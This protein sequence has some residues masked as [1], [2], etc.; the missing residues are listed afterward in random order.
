MK[1]EKEKMLAGELYLS[2]DPEIPGR[3]AA[4]K[5]WLVRVNN[6]FAEPTADNLCSP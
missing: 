5:R 2:A 6:A 4:S 3:L 1:T